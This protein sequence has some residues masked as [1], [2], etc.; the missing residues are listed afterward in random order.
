MHSLKSFRENLFSYTNQQ[1][2]TQVTQL[3]ETCHNAIDLPQDK[4][5]LSRL[6]HIFLCN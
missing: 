6:G 2:L 4:V 3:F 1:P 5:N